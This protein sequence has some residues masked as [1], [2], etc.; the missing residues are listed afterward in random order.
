M[1]WLKD[2]PLFFGMEE[3][4]IRQ[5]LSCLGM[6]EKTYEKGEYIFLSGDAAGLI[7]ILRSGSASVV[8]ED[9]W[10]NRSV[11]TKIY[12]GELFGEAFCFAQAAQV[13]VNVVSLESCEILFLRAEKIT[14]PCAECCTFH[15]QLIGNL[16]RILSGKNILLTEKIGYM[17][18][19]TTRE[20]LLSYLSSEAA[21][22]G[23]ERFEIPFNR[24]ELA[25]YLSVDR[26]AMSNELSKLGR[27]GLL[28][29]HKNRF[30]LIR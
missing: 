30:R 1:E 28:E 19:P 20:K 24:Q 14:R 12:P 29:Y 23:K 10:G 9:Y 2:T 25:D 13:P 17:S 8:K 11:Y 18:Q 22:Q 3:E 21:K 27:E 16:I 7:G 15:T 4:I 26:S 6:W 5:G